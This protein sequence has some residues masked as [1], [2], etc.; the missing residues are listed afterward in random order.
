MCRTSQIL[1]RLKDETFFTAGHLESV[2][3]QA[4]LSVIRAQQ[5]CGFAT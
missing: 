1:N 3:F 5:P 4:L 2:M